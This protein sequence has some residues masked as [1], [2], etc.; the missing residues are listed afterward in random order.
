MHVFVCH[1]PPCAP[2]LHATNPPPPK[3][4]KLGTGDHASLIAALDSDLS[5]LGQEL[6]AL[7]A[8]AAG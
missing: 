3:K 6:E 4:H 1:C 5:G 7:E 2:P 8:E